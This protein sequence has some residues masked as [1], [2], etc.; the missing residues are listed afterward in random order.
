MSFINLEFDGPLALLRLNRPAKLNAITPEML[1]DLGRAVARIE[2]EDGPRA[3]ILSGEG[4]AFSVGA[5]INVWSELS[6][7]AFRRHWVG[8]GHRAFE[9]LARCR[10]PV[11]AALHGMV[12]G[13]GLEL[14]LAAD[15]R[16][17][18]ENTLLA[19]PEAS[20]GTVP[21]WGG[22]QRLPMLIGAP[23][24]KQM[25]L[26][27]DRVDARTAERWNLVNQVTPP[28]QAFDRAREVARR[29][30]RMSPISVE[31]AKSLIDGSGGAGLGVTLETLAG[32]A[33]IATSD[34][35]EG[36]AALREKRDPK[37]EG[38]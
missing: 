12:L 14:A 25:M 4:K 31:I 1:G 13:G 3:V 15:L 26:T 23:R 29:I 36:I 35:K 21:G 33:T 7:E 9:R 30:A 19:L 27:A 37:F 6:P 17:A 16:V 20:L 5:D 10:L 22:T 34:I 11:V 8:D 24:A 32:V 28:G 18:E 38:R 2:S